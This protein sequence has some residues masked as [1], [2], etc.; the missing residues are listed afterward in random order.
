MRFRNQGEDLIYCTPDETTLSNPDVLKTA[1]DVSVHLLYPM[2]G[3]ETEEPIIQPGR[4][5]ML[6]GQGQTAQVLRNL[7][8]LVFQNAPGDWR[9]ITGLMRRL[10]SIDLDD[11]TATARGSIDLFYRQPNVKEPLEVSAAGRGTG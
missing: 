1:A 4:I 8:L 3:L 11:P 10:F 9:E 5:D 6:L 7:C 2:S